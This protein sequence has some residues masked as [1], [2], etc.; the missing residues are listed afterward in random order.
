MLP[1]S[2]TLM[3]GAAALALLGGAACS[4]R[5]ESP[6]PTSTPAV[7]QIRV[8]PTTTP[9]TG[10]TAPQ[11]TASG[12]LSTADLVKLTEASIVRI[13]T[14]TGVGSGFIVSSDGDIITNNHVIEGNNGRPSPTI[15]VTLSDGTE[16]NATLVGA[17]PKSD[18]A[19]LS[20]DMTDLAALKLGD[21][22]Q[23]SVGQ[24]VV[25]IGYALDLKRGEG[26]SFS[27]TRGIVSAKNRGIEESS[28]ILGAIQTDAAINH[29]NSGGPLLNMFGEVI[30]VNTAIAPDPTS[31]TGATAPG[32]GFA[33]G[34]DTVKAVYTE[35]N[36][37]GKVDRG[38]FG[39]QGFTALRP[40][41]A[42]ELGVPTDI[43]GIWLGEPSAVSANGPAG[44]GGLRSQD[45]I[46]KI[47]THQIRNESDLAVAMILQQPG[48]KVA[49]EYYRA[50][51]LA[52][53]EVTLGT[54]P[55]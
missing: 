3:A 5:V 17:D 54:P 4:S 39:I 26:A 55:N 21:L 24:D 27:V 40:A 31:T 2:R 49:V 10:G 52:T 7:E 18:L 6:G 14:P 43:G 45:V 35:L 28:T 9:A 48:D 25:A 41:K 50:G 19:L 46:T 12:E 22:A 13:E 23:V 30:G 1:V 36:E 33:V 38:L 37:K 32:I 53:T 20:V 47:G 51:Q 42:K 16:V 11:Q 29:G 34:V 8:S 15:R 44:I